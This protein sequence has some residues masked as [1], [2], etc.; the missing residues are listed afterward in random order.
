M[1]TQ[2]ITRTN[3]DEII[4]A[5]GIVMLDFWASW[6]MPC[7]MFGPVF[8][9]SSEAHPDIL[10]GK[11]D[12]DKQQELASAFR[13]Q[14]IPTLAA[15]RDGIMVFNQAGAIGAKQLEN[16][17]LQI[18]ALNMDDIRREIAERDEAA[19]TNSGDIAR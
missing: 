1:S 4:S 14:G 12:T 13:V 7:R 6:C 5:D 15:F 18:E 9:K 8:E 11:I 19:G 10:F 3:I 16:L 2:E 17:I